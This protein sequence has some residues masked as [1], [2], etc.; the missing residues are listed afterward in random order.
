MAKI[1]SDPNFFFRHA[2][3]I[4]IC[5]SDIGPILNPHTQ[6]LVNERLD[7]CS[8][9]LDQFNSVFTSPNINMIVHDPASFFSCQSTNP[10][11]CLTDITEPIII[12]STHEFSST[13]AT[14][15]DGV[16]SSLLLNSAAELAPA[17]KLLFSQSPAHSFMLKRAVIIPVF[18]SG[19]KTSPSNYRTILIT[20]TIIKVFEQIIRKKVVAYLTRQGYQNNTQHGFRS[21]C[22]CLSALLDVFDDR[23]HMLSMI[24]VDMIYLD[25]SK[26]FDKV[27]AYCC[28]HMVLSN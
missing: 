20:S 2:K 3:K 21:G 12:N 27:M 23:M 26:A 24:Y 5:K 28:R 9:S 18:K 17:L 14:G 16:P 8:L 1:K 7:I 25:F 10:D 13:S 11:E 15:Q 19:P 4:T 22:S 6:L